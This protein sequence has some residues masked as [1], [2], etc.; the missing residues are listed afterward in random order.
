[1]TETTVVDAI[2]AKKRDDVKRLSAATPL[3]ELRALA[4]D[5]PPTRPFLATKNNGISLIAEIKRASPSKGPIRP[6]LSPAEIAK[7]YHS[8]GAAAVSVLT[9]EHFFLGRPEFIAEV[10]SASPLPVLRKDFVFSEWQIYETR[11]LKADAVLLIAAI[12]NKNQLEDL[13]DCAIAL[14]LECLIEIH[15][16]DDLEKVPPKARVVGV[17]NRDL[18]TFHTDLAVAER[19]VPLIRSCGPD[20]RVV[21]AESGIFC[22]KDVERMQAAG[23]DAILV[24]EALMREHD[25][26]AKIAELLGRAKG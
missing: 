21:V 14:G 12:L 15:S 19:M 18:R 23:A 25:I 20:N 9:E 5:M 1:M 22:R 3:G 13:F 4:A 7:T 2:L 6:E 16:E 17:N 26:S 8:A 24:G 11:V 10:H